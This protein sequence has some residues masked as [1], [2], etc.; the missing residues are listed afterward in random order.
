MRRET[1]EIFHASLKAVDPVIA[2]KRSLKKERNTL[3]VKD[4]SFD[5]DSFE[6]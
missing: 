1:L 2:V 4:N 5:V 6:I 3:I